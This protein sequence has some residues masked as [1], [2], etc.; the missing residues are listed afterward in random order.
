MKLKNSTYDT[1]KYIALIALPAIATLY[2]AL[3]QI[4]GLP[5]AE[6]IPMTI[7]AVDTCLGVL[8]KVSTDIYHTTGGGQTDVQ[9]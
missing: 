8:L 2:G 4:W 7:M 9:D 5:Y 6:Q 3:A 1:L